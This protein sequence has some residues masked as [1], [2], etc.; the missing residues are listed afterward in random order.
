MQ[1]DATT[2]KLLLGGAATLLTF[3]LLSARVVLAIIVGAA[4]GVVGSLLLRPPPAFEP[5]AL[6]RPRAS[7]GETVKPAPSG[8]TELALPEP[9]QK[10]RLG[11]ASIRLL[12]SRALRRRRLG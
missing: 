12:P 1:R 7:A 10:V 6:P 11:S 3:S 9:L 5:V 4:A 2:Q 8:Q